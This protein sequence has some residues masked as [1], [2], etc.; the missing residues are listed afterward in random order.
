MC[1][2]EL[3]EEYVGEHGGEYVDFICERSQQSIC[4]AGVTYQPHELAARQNELEQQLAQQCAQAH[5]EVVAQLRFELEV[6]VFLRTWFDDNPELE[7]KTSGST[8]TPKVM[9]VSKERM[10]NSARL[11]LE[12]LQ[13]ERGDRALLCMPLEYIAGKM[14][15]VRALV[16]GLDL[17]V[18][19]PCGHPLQKVAAD[20]DFAAMIPLQV[21]NSLQKPGERARLAAVKQLIIGGGAIDAALEQ[22]LRSFPHKVWSTYGMTETLSHI[23]LR[24]LN[25]PEASEFYQ[26]FAQV[27]LSLSPEDTLVIEA[28]QVS[29]Q[30][31]VTNDIVVFNDQGQFRIKGRK[32]N[33]I[34]SGGIKLQIEEL[35]AQLKA[36]QPQWDFLISSQPHPKF[37]QVVVLLLTKRSL[38]SE[39]GE[40]SDLS[41]PNE[42]SELSEQSSVRAFLQTQ[43]CALTRFARPKR[44]LLVDELPR[45]GTNKPDRA[46]AQRLAQRAQAE[47]FTA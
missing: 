9:S 14:V 37:G 23:A 4:L 8:G 6:L 47:L 40:L 10:M 46:A 2:G 27:K 12:F 18:V 19:A 34:N 31:L 3:G 33:V 13:L 42:L 28:P 21:Y 25:G 41:D 16:G 38:P 22:E 26:P 7:V 39:L 44:Y 36:L 43:L 5:D 15:V 29:A 24:R 45:T 17:Q 32:D 30:T 20:L 35:E 11:T 1:V